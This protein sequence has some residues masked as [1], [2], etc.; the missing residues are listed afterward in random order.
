MERKMYGSV[1]LLGGL[2]GISTTFSFLPQVIKVIRTLSVSGISV[3][4]YVVLCLGLA[5]CIVYGIFL[6]S[7]PIILANALTLPLASVILFLKVFWGG[8]KRR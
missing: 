8:N 7:I 4:I 3:M 1:E 5:L 2:A 6:N